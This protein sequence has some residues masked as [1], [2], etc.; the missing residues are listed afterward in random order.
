MIGYPSGSARKTRGRLAGIREVNWVSECPGLEAIL[1]DV[2]CLWCAKLAASQHELGVTGL[3][4]G[5]LAQSLASAGAS[6]GDLISKGKAELRLAPLW[7]QNFLPAII[8][9]PS[10]SRKIHNRISIQDSGSSCDSLF[11]ASRLIIR[12]TPLHPSQVITWHRLA[13]FEFGGGTGIRSFFACRRHL[14]LTAAMSTIQQLKNFIRH[15]KQAR[16]VHLNDESLRKNDSA[17]AQPPPQPTDDKKLNISDPSLHQHIPPREPREAYSGVPGD[18]ANR[19]AQAAHAAAH[20][21]EQHQDIQDKSRSASTKRVDDASLA[22]LVAEEN[23]S[24]SK[25]PRYPGLER[26]DLIEKMGDG[27]FSN[28]YRA[29]DL[30]G[31]AGEVAIKVVRKY[32]MNNA[33]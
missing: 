27:A 1:P 25:F 19:V 14:C 30:Q 31:D 4:G 15:G 13:P 11:R 6:A 26:W 5:S 32:E 29:R 28:V 17:A 22:K 16:T 24:R 3:D 20:R 12:K 18:G 2:W 23:A 9:H 33:Q 10:K 7:P 21:V 8:L